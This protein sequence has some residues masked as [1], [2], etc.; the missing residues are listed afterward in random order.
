MCV[1]VFFFL[2]GE[3]EINAVVEEDLDVRIAELL[4]TASENPMVPVQ[5]CVAQVRERV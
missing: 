4:A 3:T 2:G 5:E 1:F